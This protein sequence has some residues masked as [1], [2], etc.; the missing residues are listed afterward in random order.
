MREDRYRQGHLRGPGA[1]HKGVGVAATTCAL[2]CA[3]ALSA[4][5]TTIA[6]QA[7]SGA[8]GD[9]SDP[10]AAIR[11]GARSRVG[12]DRSASP[13]PGHGGPWDFQLMPACDARRGR[14]CGPASL[15]CPAE[16]GLSLPISAP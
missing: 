10:S 14:T 11:A 9:G 6:A 5:A 8:A 1:R 2:T 15:G 16:Q 13:A 7:R 12:G 4:A 3:G